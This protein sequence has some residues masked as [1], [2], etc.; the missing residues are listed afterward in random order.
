MVESGAVYTTLQGKVDNSVIGTVEDGTTTSQAYA[1]GSHAIRNGKFITWVNAKAQ[2]EPIADSDY[3]SGNIAD[4]LHIHKKTILSTLTQI[5][6]EDGTSISFGEK[7]GNYRFIA[8][9]G[10]NANDS[11]GKRFA[12]SV[13]VD[14]FLG[15]GDTNV[16]NIHFINDSNVYIVIINATAN[17]TSIILKV[18][19]GAN[20]IISSFYIKSIIGY[21]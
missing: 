14:A 12:F 16:S 13:P 11:G 5:S 8:F 15:N 19:D 20:N 17:A 18:R 7:V 21:V 1:V 9:T 3:T 4:E 6:G 10:Y 2:N